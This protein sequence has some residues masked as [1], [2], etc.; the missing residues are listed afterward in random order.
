VRDGIADGVL[1]ERGAPQREAAVDFL[2]FLGS[3]PGME[4][5]SARRRLFW[6][7]Y[8]RSSVVRQQLTHRLLL[9]KSR[10]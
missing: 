6:R 2:R 10:V 9:V 4:I 8:N 7:N 5:F 3:K 1:F